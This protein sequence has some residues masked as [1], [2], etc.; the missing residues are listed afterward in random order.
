MSMKI[1]V[2]DGRIMEVDDIIPRE[3]KIKIRF[4]EDKN[5]NLLSFSDN[6]KS[7]VLAVNY[8]DVIKLINE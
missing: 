1:K 8:D 7:V 5:G 6:D 2:V 3:H 4:I